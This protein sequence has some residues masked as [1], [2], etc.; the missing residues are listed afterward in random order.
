MNNI[1]HSIV[2]SMGNILYYIVKFGIM[3][4]TI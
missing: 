4:I 3:S 2:K 1:D